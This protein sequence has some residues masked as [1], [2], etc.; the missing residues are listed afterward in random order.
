MEYPLEL[1]FK[2]IS[3]GPQLSVTDANGGLVFYVKQKLFKLKEEVTVFADVQ[4]ARP[5]YKINAD[6][7][8]DISARYNFRDI[9]GVDLGS[10]KREGM[11][12][13]W[14][15]HYNIFE[16]DTH[17]MTIRE[18][19]PWVKVLD[20]LVSQ[21]PIVGLFSGYFLHPAFLV[22]RAD[23]ATAMRLEKQPAFFESKFT[24]TKQVQLDESWELRVLLSLLMMILLE[25]GRG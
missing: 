25:R 19:N 17:T 8:L 1:S 3:L 11:K 14:R 24:I 21:I 6:R 16:G 9:N 22:S 18:E 10:V 23:G 2:I 5:L 4:Q 15:A 7:V 12:S 13:L 20:G